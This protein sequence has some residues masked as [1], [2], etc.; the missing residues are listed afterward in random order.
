MLTTLA[1]FF[2][3]LK[4]KAMSIGLMAGLGGLVIAAVVG[5][6]LLT[7]RQQQQLADAKDALKTMKKEYDSETTVDRLSASAVRKRL[8][9]EW[10]KR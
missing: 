8:Q 7:A 3:S 4:S 9:S 5:S 10:L 1:T 6:L 2:L